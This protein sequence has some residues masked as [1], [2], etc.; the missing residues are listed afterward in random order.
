MRFAR[1][2]STKV[3]PFVTLGLLVCGISGCST[4]DPKTNQP[5]VTT[6]AKDDATSP[7]LIGDRITIEFSG[8]PSPIKPMDTEIKGNGCIFFDFIGDVHLDGLTAGQAEKAIEALYVPRYY[9]HLAVTVTPV[10][11]FFYVDGE[12]NAAGAGSKQPYTGQISVTR[13]IAAAGGFSPFA[14]RRN[15]RLYRRDGKYTVVNCV[16]ALEHPELDL[17]VY[18]GDRILVRKRPW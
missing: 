16:K 5:A 4:S 3:L 11:R 8:P 18:P 2:F 15:V 17:P 12:V 14:N 10:M 7:L 9:T 13:A 1:H 6:G